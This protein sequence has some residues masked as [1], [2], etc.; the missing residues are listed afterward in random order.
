MGDLNDFLIDSKHFKYVVPQDILNLKE[1]YEGY[2]NI[3]AVK[4]GRCDKFGFFL[5]SYKF[6]NKTRQARL[7]W[8]EKNSQAVD[9]FMHYI[10]K[11]KPFTFKEKDV[12]KLTSGKNHYPRIFVDG[13][14]LEEIGFIPGQIVKV[15]VDKS[16]GVVTIYP[17]RAMTTKEREELKEKWHKSNKSEW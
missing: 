16:A 17:N 11:E 3:H 9:S 13:K 6:T 1:D 5:V 8:V 7:L 14:M 15:F 4:V 2:E 12:T 10:D